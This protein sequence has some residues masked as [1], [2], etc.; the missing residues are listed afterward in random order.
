MNKDKLGIRK[1][2]LII[3]SVLLIASIIGF[4]AFITL[5]YTIKQPNN[6]ISA[7]FLLFVIISV[8]AVGIFA[9]L[10]VR[11][12][13]NRQIIVKQSFDN[14][15]DEMISH[16]LM[17]TI[18]FDINNKI[19]WTSKFIRKRFGRKWIGI[20]LIA[21]FQTCGIDLANQ[22]KEFEFKYNNFYYR[23][24][25]WNLNNSLSIKDITLEKNVLATYNQEA[26][27]LGELEIDNYPL[28]QSVLSEEQIYNLNKE[29]IKTL[30]SLVARYNFVYR[31][32]NTNG[33]FLIITNKL[34][35]EAMKAVN[36]KFFDE[37]H[38]I[39]V[40]SES[41]ITISISVGFIEGTEN[42]N[43]K[44]QKAKQALL[45]A[46]S[47]GGDQVAIFSD[48]DVARY[49][50]S[51][52]EILPNIDR[53]RIKSF[54]SLLAER[55]KSSDVEQV[56][57]YGHSNADLDAIGSAL[58]LVALAK[59]FKKPAYICTNTQDDTTKRI[60][61][62]YYED[63]TVF[64]KSKQAEKLSNQKTLVVFVD[65]S[66]PTRTDNPNALKNI[67]QKNV[68][69]IDHHR[70]GL[71][72]DFAPKA[73]RII[74]PS[75]SSASEIV[76]EILMFI[77]KDINVDWKTAQMLLNGIYLDTLQFQKH[78][79]FKTFEAASWLQ[80]KGADSY[81]SSETLKIDT[82]T[83][84]KVNELLEN[85]QEVKPGYYLAYKDIELSNDVISIAAEEIL[86]I[87]GRK[88]SFVIAKTEKGNQYK[89]SA[90]GLETN[91]QIIAEAVGG[92]GHFGTAAAVSDEK[93]DV[94]VDN[95]KQ[96]I[97]SV[98]NYD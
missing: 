82:E 75:V 97:V 28:Y 49:Y 54:I 66:H 16:N 61:K 53:T 12:Y 43:V 1:R 51:T 2:N 37:L 44:M 26:I 86:R 56:I 11:E 83:Y 81:K 72:I 7:I 80:S 85:L 36:F 93:L 52:R 35:L 17:G 65:N 76:T 6:W 55:M 42:L 45:Q 15:I 58:G 87:S 62:N 9:T 59:A 60:I 79:T 57:I 41:N 29:V 64:I 92:G 5:Y 19:L 25:L 30:D 70:L 14:Y 24:K 74:D 23:V 8:L 46:Q 63:S 67:L 27:V 50:G 13:L 95:I 18:I 39:L 94:F 98:K 33:K 96:A 40:D 89:L 90:R 71:A 73:N 32:Y 68:F 21:F 77:E 4:I 47:R 20:S 34:S 10:S 91:V 78:V 3:F 22:E 69:V 31:Q 38:N 88:A 84:Q 48:L